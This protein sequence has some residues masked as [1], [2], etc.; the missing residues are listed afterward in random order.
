[1]DLRDND[2]TIDGLVH[3]M[4][5]VKTSD[6]SL[7]VLDVSFNPIGDDG[8]SLISSELQYNN[9][10]TELRVERCSL[11]VK[12]A[13]CIS[14]VLGKCS[15]QVLATAG[16]NIGDDGITAIAEA[17]SNSQ[18]NELN[19]ETCGITLTGAKSLAALASIVM[20]TEESQKDHPTITDAKYVRPSTFVFLKAALLRHRPPC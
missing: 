14:E 7:R 11:S 4:K 1:M 9:I 17:L 10:L 2:L 19:V 13:I 16:N 3:L 5:I 12:G 20:V 18:I 6:A 15:L 8:M